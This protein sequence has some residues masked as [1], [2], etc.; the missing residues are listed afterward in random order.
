MKG[1]SAVFLIFCFRLPLALFFL[2]ADGVLA[3]MAG[4]LFIQQE[5]YTTRVA[6]FTVT[7]KKLLLG[8]SARSLYH[9]AH[10]L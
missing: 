10:T 2:V 1:S 7:T 3:V 8:K 4:G 9:P 6:N 5:K